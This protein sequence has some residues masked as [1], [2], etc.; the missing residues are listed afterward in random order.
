MKIDS[1]PTG[2][3]GTWLVKVSTSPEGCLVV[4]FSME[5]HQTYVQF[6][7]NQEDAKSFIHRVVFEE[8]EA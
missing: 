3:L 8:K 6:L 2:V 4:L 5:H 1:L 7:N